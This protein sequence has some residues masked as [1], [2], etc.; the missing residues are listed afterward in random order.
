MLLKYGLVAAYGIMIIV[1]G[2][3]GMKK[4]RSFNDYFL[5]GGKVGAIMTAFTYGTAYFS[6]VLFI[7]FAGKIGWG[8]GYS[9]MW[10][11]VTNAIIGV[12]F[13][14]LFVGPR[15]KRVS[16]QMKVST[17]AEFLERRYNSRIM[18][19]MAAVSIFIFFVPYSAAVFMGLS[20]LFETNFNMPYMYALLIMGSLTT[21]YLVMGGYKSMTMIDVIFGII[22]TIGVVILLG[23]TINRG[24][25]IAN[26]TSSLAAIDPKLVKPVGPPGIWPLLS[27]I[28]LTSVAPFAMPQLIQKFYAIKDEKA[29]KKG[30]VA[31]TLFALLIG[32]VAYFCG[33]TTRA[34]LMDNTGEFPY[35]DSLYLNGV[36]QVD[37]LMP[38][39]LTNI[40]PESL[41]IIMLLLILSASMSTL[42]ALVLISS[43]SIAKDIYAG[44][45]NPNVRDRTLT[46]LM[47]IGSAFFI[48]LSVILAA[49]KPATIVSILGISWG[50]IGSVF[51][52]P[53]MWG[54][55]TKKVNDVGAIS[56]SVLGLGT[57]LVLY[58]MMGPSSSP[59]A[60]SIGMIVSVVVCPLFSLLKPRKLIK[61]A[62]EIWEKHHRD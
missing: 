5:G 18:R 13:V 32:G 61:P 40:I 45:I 43:S 7:G 1:I 25:G 31:S 35:M 28:M 21:V 48:L 62:H 60:G 22:M 19:F 34:L 16:T 29:I 42:A 14:W 27:L 24:G 9:G 2:I 55:F 20:Y 36:L 3:M 56:A 6:A 39:L 12:L 51:L 8:F 26:I 49:T 50:A 52:G 54:L 53:F 47:R 58:V 57:C 37:R 33:A 11:A 30:L 4:T 46:L 59:Q 17:M 23:F 15:I 38:E 41:S 10:I 44:F